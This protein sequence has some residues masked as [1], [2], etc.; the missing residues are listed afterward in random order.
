MTRECDLCGEP[1][2]LRSRDRRTDDAGS[3]SSSSSE[4]WWDCPCGRT[5]GE[6]A[7][8]TTATVTFTDEDD[9]Q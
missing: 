5:I 2:V 4:T 9:E 7:A 3:I 6:F 1:M 8:S